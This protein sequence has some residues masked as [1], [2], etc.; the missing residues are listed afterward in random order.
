VRIVTRLVS[1]VCGFVVVVFLALLAL[2]SDSSIQADIWIERPPEDV[3]KVLAATSEYGSWNPMISRM[4]GELREGNIIEFVEGS[5][6]DGMVFHPTILVA[7]PGKELTWMGHVWFPGIFDG[8]H[9]FTL[10]G[11]G[12]RT[13]FIQRERFSGWLVGRL[14]K[15]ILVETEHQMAEMN[16]ELKKR[17]E[18]R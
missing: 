6:T 7:K 4:S 3:W 15:G 11:T 17:V 16:F 8:E 14:T 18:A 1:W 5:A 10:D 9:S 2:H 12:S 13:H